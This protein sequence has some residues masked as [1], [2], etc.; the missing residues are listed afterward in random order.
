[1]STTTAYLRNKFVPFEDANLSIASSPILYGLS[2]Y[3]VFSANWNETAQQL[4]IFRLPDHYKRL[5]NSAKIMDFHSFTAEWTYKKFERTMIELLRKITFGNLCWYGS[6]C[7][8][9]S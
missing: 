1:M 6:R 7:L 5:V 2:V 3:T 9:M 4:Y 8:L